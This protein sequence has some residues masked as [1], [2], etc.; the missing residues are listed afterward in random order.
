ERAVVIGDH[1]HDVRGALDAGARCVAV[2][3]GRVS[4]DE[5]RSAG[6]HAVLPSLTDADALLSACLAH[7]RAHPSSAD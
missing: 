1:V 3:T 5:L 6:A 4:A 2:A 7:T